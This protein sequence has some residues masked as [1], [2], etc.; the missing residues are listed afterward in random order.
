MLF[1]ACWHGID[2]V[3]VINDTF[4]NATAEHSKTIAEHTMAIFKKEKFSGG[5]RGFTR[6]MADYLLAQKHELTGVILLSVKDPNFNSIKIKR[7]KSG[8]EYLI[9]MPLF[10]RKI[11]SAK[12]GRRFFSSLS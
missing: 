2:G 4:T 11:L 3:A 6:L 8:T 12:T 1:R 9:R 10:M 7:G 5:P